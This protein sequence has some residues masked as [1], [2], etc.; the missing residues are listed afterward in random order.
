MEFSVA[1]YN[2]SDMERAKKFY[3][4]VLGLTKRI[5]M[6]GWTTFSHAEGATAIGLSEG[7]GT[8]GPGGA[9]AVFR[10]PDLDRA[11]K[12]LAARG[13]KFDDKIEEIPGM[14]RIGTFHDP[15]GNRLQLVQLLMTN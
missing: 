14:V 11:R 3:G 2:V 9:T 13:V 15:F 1:W 5:E 4:D 12:E 6:Q 10:V 7:R 8:P